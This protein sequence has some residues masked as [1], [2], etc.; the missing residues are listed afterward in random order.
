VILQQW[1]AP[2]NRGGRFSAKD[3]AFPH[4]VAVQALA[5]A[6]ASSNF[7]A[8]DFMPRTAICAFDAMMRA[9]LLHAASRSSA[10]IA[11]SR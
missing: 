6:A 4:F 8:R 2:E 1:A 3:A 5:V 11:S 7:V 9:K 10:G